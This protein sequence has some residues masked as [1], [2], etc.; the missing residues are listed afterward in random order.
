MK[1]NLNTGLNQSLNESLALEARNMI[2]SMGSTESKEAITAFMGKRLP[3][4]R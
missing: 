2:E 3:V 1:E 4:F